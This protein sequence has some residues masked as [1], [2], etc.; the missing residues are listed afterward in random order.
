MP[1]LPTTLA[2]LALFAQSRP[3]LSHYAGL[4]CLMISTLTVTSCAAVLPFLQRGSGGRARFAG[5]AAIAGAMMLWSGREL[6][7]MIGL[8]TPEQLFV[9]IALTLAL[10]VGVCGAWIVDVLRHRLIRLEEET[11]LVAL[12]LAAVPPVLMPRLFPVGMQ[13]RL[14]AVWFLHGVFWQVACTLCIPPWRRLFPPRPDPV[15]VGALDCHREESERYPR[16][17][18]RRSD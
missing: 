4:V 17:K 15:D 10:V 11:L 5:L 16:P 3:D 18:R 8:T 6:D 14:L 12:L 7:Q 13:P 1:L 9:A 2:S